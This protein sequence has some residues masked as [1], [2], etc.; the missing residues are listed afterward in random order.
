MNRPTTV[1]SK[2]SL[3]LVIR[4]VLIYIVLIIFL[5][6]SI[7][8]IVWI[9]LAALKAATELNQNPFAFPKQFTFDNIKEAWTVGK[10]GQYFL[11]SVIVAVPRVF[12]ILILASLAGYAFGKL[13]F[14]GRNALFY[15]FLFGMMIPIQAMIIPLYYNMQSLNLIN[16]YWALIL[17]NF[18]LAM[19]FAIFMMRAF[20]R[21][22]PD[23]LM[24]AARIDGCN[25]FTAFT[26]IMLPLMVPAI[27]SLLIFEFMWSWNDFLLPLLF[28]YDDAYRTLPLGLMYFSGEYTVNQSLVAAGVSIAIVPIIIIYIIF[29][30]KFIEGITAGSV[31]G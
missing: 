12:V 13:K 1:V 14:P 26:Y 10:M 28:V 30:R 25:D 2:N 11:N 22:L 6:I 16:S 21:D 17:P 20:Y 31:K 15:F 19:P 4:K 29:Q 18:G 3:P 9:V 5:L 24:D 7:M 8:P 23:E 27:T